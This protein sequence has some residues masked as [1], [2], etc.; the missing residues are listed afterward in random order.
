MNMKRSLASVLCLALLTGCGQVDSVST[1]DS[2]PEIAVSEDTTLS[3]D[4]DDAI[5]AQTTTKARGRE[6]GETSS[7][8]VTTKSAT[9]IVTRSASD[10]A[11]RAVSPANRTGSTV[12]TSGNTSRNSSG[13]RGNS[14]SRQNQTSTEPPAESHTE[15]PT[16]SISY[17]PSRSVTNG[18]VTCW[19][20]EDGVAV[21]RD[22][23]LIQLIEVDSDT[24]RYLDSKATLMD[25]DF[26]DHDDLFIPIVSGTLNITGVYYHY[27]TKTQSFVEWDEMNEVNEYYTENVDDGII[28]VYIRI[29]A[30]ENESRAYEWVGD[31]LVLRHL[32]TQYRGDDRELYCDYIDYSNGDANL[33]KREHYII[34]EDG[35]LIS[36]E[37]VP[38][39]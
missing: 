21:T 13:S 14:S 34:N 24:L 8:A 10:I 7:T 6:D 4:A 18:D 12:R 31:E 38:V 32:R 16:A 5:D 23:K 36:V 11:T 20:S 29:S 28:N 2:I 19:A 27:D 35:E 22:G 17:D 25:Y 26:D 3:S 39:A 30:S 1:P 33:Y 37:E 9:L 15:T